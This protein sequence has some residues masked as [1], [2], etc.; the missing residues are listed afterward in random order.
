MKM[1]NSGE[2]LCA[3]HLTIETHDDLIKEVARRTSRVLDLPEHEVYESFSKR[4]LVGSTGLEKGVAI[5]HCALV[6][7]SHFVC[8]IITL[9]HPIPFGALDGNPSDIFVFV[10]GP[11]AQRNDHVRLLA[12][13]TAHVRDEAVRER[14]RQTI[15]AEGLSTELQNWLPLGDRENKTNRTLLLVHVQDPTVFEPVLELLSGELNASV[16]VSTVHSAGTVLYRMPLFASF[17]NENETREIKRI[18]AIVPQDRA[19]RVIRRINDLSHGQG[20]H[21]GAIDLSYGAGQIAL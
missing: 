7:S 1:R 6:T 2:Q 10:A 11:E 9:S 21:V 12:A 8:G 18:E 14:V 4:E 13:I 19:N 3:A 5:P 16:S 15:T 20:V 17:W